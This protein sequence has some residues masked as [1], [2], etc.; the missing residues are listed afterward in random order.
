MQMNASDGI[1][2]PPPVFHDNTPGIPNSLGT[3]IVGSVGSG[4]SAII[5]SFLRKTIHVEA[6]YREKFISCRIRHTA[7][8]IHGF[9]VGL[10]GRIFLANY[11][12][13]LNDIEP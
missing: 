10:F 7:L 12:W 11:E 3:M 5:E 2:L 1:G 13:I 8:G 4:R 6:C 9:G